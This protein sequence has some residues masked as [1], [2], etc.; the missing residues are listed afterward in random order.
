V[1]AASFAAGALVWNVRDRHRADAENVIAWET[2]PRQLAIENLGHRTVTY[3]EVTIAD[4]TGQTLDDSGAAAL[5]PGERWLFSYATPGVENLME[6]YPKLR[7]EVYFTDSAGK[8][9]RRV[10]PP[11][12]LHMEKQP[13]RP[14]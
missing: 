10:W 5:T 12:R 3:V 8:H 11:G 9:W 2:G 4:E 6:R 1:A 14:R 13:R 7:A